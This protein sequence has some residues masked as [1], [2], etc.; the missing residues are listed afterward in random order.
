MAEAV[1]GAVPLH[2]SPQDSASTGLKKS[3]DSKTPGSSG[4]IPKGG[5]QE[6]AVSRTGSSSTTRPSTA[7]EKKL[8]P[9]K[10]PVGNAPPPKIK[11]ARSKI[12]SLDNMTHKPKGGEK[13]VEHVKLEWSAKSKVG[14]LDYATH[15]PGGGDKKILTQKVDFKNV[16]SKVGSKDNLKHKPGGGN[17][18]TPSEK[19]DFKSK[20]ASRVGSL[21]NAKHKPGG[22]N[23]LIKTEKL[24]FKD[25]AAAKIHS[26][27][28]S[29]KGSSH[30]GSE[31]QSPV[32]P[33]SPAP[34][35]GMP[36][37]CEDDNPSSQEEEKKDVEESPAKVNNVAECNGGGGDVGSPVSSPGDAKE[38][39]EEKK[40]DSTVS[41]VK[42][43]S[44]VNG[45]DAGPDC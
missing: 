2:L 16:Q 21:E 23:V 40:E 44:V 43:N 11:Q 10:A 30:G 25:K 26:R 42:E 4:A 27:S 20:A 38:V 31:T 41:A 22:G 15:K 13:K 35:E 18:K 9:I 39:D 1:A 14:S 8:P 17:A 37:L 24:H 32:L 34:P 19:L 45:D 33:S 6:K 12:G 28:G 3:Q 36:P 5:Q 29:E 7:T